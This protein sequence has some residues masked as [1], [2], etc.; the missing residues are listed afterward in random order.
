[1]DFQSRFS[2]NAYFTDTSVCDVADE[3]VVDGFSLVWVIMWTFNLHLEGGS[4]ENYTVSKNWVG[5]PTTD[6]QL[7]QFKIQSYLQKRGLWMPV[8]QNPFR[9]KTI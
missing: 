8:P 6:I 2:R 4:M 5:M 3:F 9:R 7:L 1:M